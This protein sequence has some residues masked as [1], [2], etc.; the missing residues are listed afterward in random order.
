MTFLAFFVRFL[1][2]WIHDAVERRL[3]AA[4][5]D[6]DNSDKDDDASVDDDEYGFDPNLHVWHPPENP[7]IAEERPDGNAYCYEIVRLTK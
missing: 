7:V 1:K 4:A 2:L 5:A 3:S 6:E